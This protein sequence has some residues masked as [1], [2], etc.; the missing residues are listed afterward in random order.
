MQLVSSA[1]DS[2]EGP[3][4][5]ELSGV[6]EL[7]AEQQ[8]RRDVHVARM[9]MALSMKQSLQPSWMPFTALKQVMALM[10]G[11]S[12]VADTVLPSQLRVRANEAFFLLPI[13]HVAVLARLQA[14]MVQAQPRGI[15]VD[16]Q[17]V[18]R[19]RGHQPRQVAVWRAGC[20]AGA[21]TRRSPNSEIG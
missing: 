3:A 15:S 12:D 14:R 4:P 13:R 9:K 18:Q 7:S 20:E 17:H 1:A 10:L 21:R 8:E 5:S 16:M 2:F 11:S 19:R 6:A